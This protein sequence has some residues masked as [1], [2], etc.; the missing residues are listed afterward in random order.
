MPS[1]P[2]APPRFDLSNPDIKPPVILTGY[3]GKKTIFFRAPA[4]LLAKLKAMEENDAVRV[5]EDGTLLANGSAEIAPG[6]IASV[7]FCGIIHLTPLNVWMD[8]WA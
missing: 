8:T 3:R 2:T 7:P 5:L 1:S 4:D 6:F